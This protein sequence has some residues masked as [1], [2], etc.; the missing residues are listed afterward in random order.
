MHLFGAVQG[1]GCTI[2]RDALFGNVRSLHDICTVLYRYS[3]LHHVLPLTMVG[4]RLGDVEVCVPDS[5]ELRKD[6][7]CVILGRFLGV[8]TSW[9]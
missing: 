5:E 1:S 7:K 9:G 6:V 2:V 8:R 3:L 4:V